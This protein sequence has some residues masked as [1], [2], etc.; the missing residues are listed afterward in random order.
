MGSMG[1]DQKTD[2]N[3]VIPVQRDVHGLHGRRDTG[4]GGEHPTDGQ[5]QMPNGPGR[6]R[7]FKSTQVSHDLVREQEMNW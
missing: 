7:R 6:T 5:L 3:N 2:E 1:R 4:D